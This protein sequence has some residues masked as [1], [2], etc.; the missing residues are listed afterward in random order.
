MGGVEPPIF[1]LTGRRLTVWPH[2]IISVRTV[3]FEPTISCSRGTRNA[4]LSHV[5]NLESAQPELNRHLL[6]GKQVRYHY[7]MSACRTTKLSKIQEHREGLEPSSP[8]DH[9]SGGARCGVFAAGSPVLVLQ[10]GPEG[11]EPSPARLRAGDA[12]TNTSVPSIESARWESN[13]R[14]ASYKDAALTTEL[15]ASRASRAGGI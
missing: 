3:G 1:G 8:H 15:R 12:A 13:P 14:P 10:V 9:P 7:A 11:L 6:H 2:R 5:L 4:R